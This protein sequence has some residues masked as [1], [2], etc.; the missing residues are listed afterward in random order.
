MGHYFVWQWCFT[1]ALNTNKRFVV[2]HRMCSEKEE[3]YDIQ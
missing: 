3:N 1:Q 2:F